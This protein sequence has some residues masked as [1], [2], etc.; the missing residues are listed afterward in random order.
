MSKIQTDT[1]NNAAA[2][3]LKGSLFTLTVLE[4]LSNNKEIFAAQLQR[5]IERT[6][7][8]FKNMPLVIDCKN[9]DDHE[10][11]DLTALSQVLRQN[12]VIPV[13]V[14]NAS[15]NLQSNAVAAGLGI[16]TDAKPVAPKPKPA[17]KL[18]AKPVETPAK[19]LASMMITKPVRSGQQ[20]YAK[21][22]DLIVLANISNDAELLADGNIHVYGSLQGRAM[23]GVS[24]DKT[25]RIFCQQLAANM[26][27]IA[28]IYKLHDD[29]PNAGNNTNMQVYLNE[30]KLIIE[31]I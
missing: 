8:F 14:R 5:L 24:G 21:G 20:I 30:D 6:P 22:R 26:V 28:G 1:T 12:G 2:F 16:L 31:K 13:G 3:Q 4:L 17:P 11:L 29:I 10:G 27:S 7:N 18:D 19:K 25:A 9:I 15:A 23:A